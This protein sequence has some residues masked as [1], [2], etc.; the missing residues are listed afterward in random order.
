MDYKKDE[1]LK[2]AQNEKYAGKEFDNR[3]ES[4]A[5][6]WASLISLIVGAVLFF[7]ELL[8]KGTWNIALIAVAMTASCVELLYEGIKLKKVWKI[9]IGAI[10]ALIALFFILGFIGQVIS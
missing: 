5:T 4:R 9:I 6:L 3:T 7:V 1:I 8:A 2:A 10:G